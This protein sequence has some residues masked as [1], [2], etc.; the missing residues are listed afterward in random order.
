MVSNAMAEA[1]TKHLLE[2][3]GPPP[4]QYLDEADA[5]DEA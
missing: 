4:T 3:Y 1:S 2:A 5:S